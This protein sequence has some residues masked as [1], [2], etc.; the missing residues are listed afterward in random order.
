MQADPSQV[1]DFRMEEMAEHLEGSAPELWALMHSLL[2]GT[3]HQSSTARPETVPFWDDPADDE[4]WESDD[5]LD[6]SAGSSP[7]A[8]EGAGKRESRCAFLV[9][10]R[11]V[12]MISIMMHSQ[13]QRCNALQ[14][15]TGI[16]LHSC[17]APEKLVKVL[18]RMGL[19]ISLRTIHRAVKSLSLHSVGDVEALAQTLCAA[20]ALDNLDTK[21]PAGIPTVDKTAD[22]LIHI[23]TGTLL[24]LEHGV[25]AEDLRCSKLLWERS[26]DNP[27][28]SDPRPY[29]AKM[30]IRRLLTLHPEPDPP[31]RS[32]SRRGRYRAWHLTNVL[33]K[34]GPALLT[35]LRKNLRDPEVLDQIPVTTL[36]QQ[37]VCAMDINLSTVSGNLEALSGLYSQGGVGDPFENPSAPNRSLRDLSEYVTI[38][39]GDL[40]TYEHVLTAKRRRKQER[41]PF[42]RLQHVVFVPGL[43]HFKMAAA[44]ALWR[45]LVMP[46][47]SRVDDTSFMKLV[48]QL[49]PDDSSRLVLNAKFR[50][51]HDLINHVGSVLI[52]DAWRAEVKK[53]WG[54]TTLEEWAATKPGL[55]DI[56]E[57]ANQL[58]L[59]YVEGDG[60]DL[61][62]Y[63]LQ[64]SNRRDKV[65]ENTLRTLNYLLL[66]EE[67][68][69]AMNN[70]DI[71]RLETLFLPWIQ[72]FRSVGKHKYANHTL[73]FLHALYFIYP[74]GLRQVI[75]YNILVNPTGKPKAFRAVDWVVEL[76]NL[77]IKVRKLYDEVTDIYDKND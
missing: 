58:A 8:K 71:G 2:G 46:D 36:V 47:G 3:P 57:V 22:G 27:T 65:K 9:R 64:G 4:Y 49:R 50:E 37:P 73:R 62:Q 39:H 76:L 68:S 11:S 29:D 54:Y 35:S 32:L 5:D 43:F 66:Y 51:R 42:N 31:L 16:F 25:Q 1:R 13:D 24:R 28:A 60:Q 72:I 38:V 75:R 59:E 40:G 56:E 6:A 70:G 34:H 61:G 69:H 77:Y 10:I 44:D 18:S 15:V 14:S 21:L 17:G 45:I 12:V 26:E 41:T 52:L 74:D 19:S 7:I 53:R 23:T 33:M 55:A 20:Y 30:T 48:G 63:E 67:L